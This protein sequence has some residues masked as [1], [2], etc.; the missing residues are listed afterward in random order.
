[1]ERNQPREPTNLL[2]LS[3]DVLHAFY[4]SEIYKEFT[5]LHLEAFSTWKNS[6]SVGLLTVK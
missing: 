1:M 3:G 6:N 5:C 4:F 2:L